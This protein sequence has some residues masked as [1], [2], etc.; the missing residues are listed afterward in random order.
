MNAAVS[1]IPATA[2]LLRVGDTQE[3]FG[4]IG[5]Q[6]KEGTTVLAEGLQTLCDEDIFVVS[7]ETQGDWRVFVGQVATDHGIVETPD[8][9]HLRS[10]VIRPSDLACVQL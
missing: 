9:L 8:G 4:R 3:F 6:S 5:S 2:R 1:E 7:Y 10:L